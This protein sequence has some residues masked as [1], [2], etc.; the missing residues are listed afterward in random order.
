MPRAVAILRA[1]QNRSGEIVDTVLLDYDQ[2]RTPDGVL[3]G[4]K[5]TQVQVAI[6]KSES[7]ATDDCLV[8]DDGRLIEIVARPEPLLEVR[9]GDAAGMARLAWHLGDRH[10]PAE[11]HERRLRVRR[12]PAVEKLLASL[13]AKVLPIDAPFQPEGGAYSGGHQHGGHDHRHHGAND[14]CDHH[15]HDH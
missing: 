4:L 2:R 1:G 9:A 3:T 6:A 5:G 7:L 13:G 14:H 15:D 12:D 8:L 11:L 10:I